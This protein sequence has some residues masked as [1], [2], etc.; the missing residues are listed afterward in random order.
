MGTHES[1]QESPGRRIRATRQAH[2]KSLRTLERLDGRR[3]ERGRW[4]RIERGLHG[5]SVDDLYAF[6]AVLG[7]R[8]LA[9]TLRPFATDTSTGGKK[10]PRDP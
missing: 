2:G 8:D 1:T 7:L 9:K 10:G 3:F 6:A 5:L 4:S